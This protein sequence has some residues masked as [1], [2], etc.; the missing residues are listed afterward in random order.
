VGYGVGYV[1]GPRNDH[2]LSTWQHALIV[3]RGLS[4][5]ARSARR[6][7]VASNTSSSTRSVP[8]MAST[9]SFDQS[10]YS[11][12]RLRDHFIWWAVGDVAQVG[13]LFDSRHE[14]RL[15]R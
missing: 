7:N 10:K 1:I 12:F 8:P 13:D 11:C 5:D 6:A 15:G 4:P 3:A 9:T 14:S 2:R